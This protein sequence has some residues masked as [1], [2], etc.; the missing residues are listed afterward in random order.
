LADRKRIAVLGSTGSIGRSVLSVV[1]SNPEAFEVVS[2][3]AFTSAELLSE[4]AMRLG[5]G[6]VAIGDGAVG[7]LDPSLDI[8]TGEDGLVELAADPSADLI[9][10]ALVGTAGL[11]VTLA[12]VG[13]GKRL[14]LANK[15]SLVM[16][17][18]VVTATARETGSEL[19]PV[20]S[21][22][23]SIFRCLRGA[24][25]G[26]VLGVVLTA[27]GGPLRDVP[28]ER[29]CDAGVDEVLSHPTWDMGAKI[30]VDSATLVNKA[31]EVIEAAWLF[32]LRLDQIGTVVHRES[33]VHSFVTMS[34][35]SMLAHLGAPDMRV[36][37]Q[38]A[39]F[40]PEA[41]VVPFEELAPA[42]MGSLSFTAVEPARYPCFPL[43]LEAGAQGGTAPAVAVTA[44]EVA[45]DA[46]LSRGL[47]F[48]DIATVISSTME[49]VETV[50]SDDLPAIEGAQERARARASEIVE[51]LTG[52]AGRS[53]RRPTVNRERHR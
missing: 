33:I 38:Y 42:D 52:G 13:A 34:D 50:A 31:F 48:G 2:L 21:E 49:S 30:T 35:G 22:H 7:G 24:A 39:L 19:I 10:N 23:S 12:A 29:I 5:V 4:Q 9:V 15:E 6:R 46:F 17:G 14:A 40:Y 3:S 44:D 8:L 26:E 27:S 20:D 25:A 36:P 51:E 28:L 11:P 1:E 43:L 16:A 45:V 32:D 47:R 37:I 18:R 41:P 53:A